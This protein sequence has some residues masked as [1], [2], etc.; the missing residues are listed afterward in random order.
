MTNGQRP[1][2]PERRHLSRHQTPRQHVV[3]GDK[4]WH[5]APVRLDIDS[6]RALRSVVDAGS[7]T[8]AAAELALTQSA[9]SWKIKRLE[10]RVG[11]PLLVRDGKAIRPTEIGNELLFHADKILAAHDDAV[12]S[13]TRRSLSGTVVLGCND[14]PEL[15]VIADIIRSFR[16]EHPLVG[17]HTRIAPSSVLKRRLVSGEIDIALLQILEVDQTDEDLVVSRDRLAWFAAEDLKIPTSRI[18]PLITFG[19]NCFYEPVAAARLSESGL[20]YEV[21]VECENSIGVFSAVEAGLGVALLN[22]KHPVAES[23]AIRGEQLDLPADLPGV[24][25]V[26]RR[27][28]RASANGEVRALQQSL[29]DGLAV[30]A[31]TAN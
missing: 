1:P 15:T 8:A 11:N 19:P 21:T 22:S 24:L 13:L 25:F 4:I 5:A 28:T 20:H 3:Y 31:E 30:M 26:A 27:G 18:V 23:T 12:A 29:V 10:E 2:G 7:F 17:V 14:E 9:V 6:L 16:K